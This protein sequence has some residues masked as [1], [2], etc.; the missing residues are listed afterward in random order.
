MDVAWL[1]TCDANNRTATTV[2][3]TAACTDGGNYPCYSVFTPRIGVIKGWGYVS[4]RATQS[5][6]SSSSLL[7]L[8]TLLLCA[9]R[10]QTWAR[11]VLSVPKGPGRS[12][13]FTY[14][15]CHPILAMEE[16]EIHADLLVRR[17]FFYSHGNKRIGSF[18]RLIGVLIG[19]YDHCFAT[20]PQAAALCPRSSLDLKHPP[21]RSCPNGITGQP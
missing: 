11:A 15:L 17:F 4:S 2:G 12:S 1:T 8:L 14:R 9:G 6:F 21:S 19:V 20:G 10:L 16:T 3:Y 5:Y 13:R 18:R 7:F